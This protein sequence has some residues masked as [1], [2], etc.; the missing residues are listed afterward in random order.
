MASPEGHLHHARKLAELNIAQAMF[1]DL[2][3]PADAVGDIDDWMDADD[4]VYA[5]MFT[6]WADPGGEVS[7]LGIQF[8][9]GRPVE[10]DIINT[11]GDGPMTGEQARQL[12]AALIAAADEAERMER[13]DGITIS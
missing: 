3:P 6:S 11:G 7:I 5:R 12:A 4:W 9:D 2:A 10:R 13:Y 8:S 1:A